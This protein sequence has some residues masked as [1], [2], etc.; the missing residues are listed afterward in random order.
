[1]TSLAVFFASLFG[2]PAVGSWFLPSPEGRAIKEL[3][4]TCIAAA[5]GLTTGL[6]I[7]LLAVPVSWKAATAVWMVYLTGTSILLG[8]IAQIWQVPAPGRSA[9]PGRRGSAWI[10]ALSFFISA[11]IATFAQIAVAAVLAGL[12]AGLG[13]PIKDPQDFFKS[14]FINYA[15]LC[16]LV[17]L[18][19]F[20]SLRWKRLNTPRD[21]FTALFSWVW[22]TSLGIFLVQGV[23]GSF[24]RNIFG[25]ELTTHFSGSRMTLMT[26]VFMFAGLPLV[27]Y[28]AWGRGS[29]GRRFAVTT[30]TMC[31]AFLSLFLALGMVPWA[32]CA[33]GRH[34]EKEGRPQA[35]LAWYGRS[36]ERRSTPLVVSY[37]EH[38][39]GL[40]NYKLGHKK[41]AI[42]AFKL[43]QTTNNANP[44]LARSAELYLDRLLSGAGGKR[45]VL[46]G[47]ETATDYRA[48][49]CAPNTLSVVLNYLHKDVSAS[50]VGEAISMVYQGTSITDI[51]LYC[52]R[53]GLDHILIPFATP[54]DCRFVIDHGYPFI[55][56]LPG[57]V[58]AVFGYD[59]RLRTLIAYDT[60]TWDIWVDHP[61]SSFLV[62]WSQENYLGAVILPRRRSKDIDRIRERYLNAGSRAA[63][64]MA[65][66]EN[67][68]WILDERRHLLGALAA[69]PTCLPAALNLFEHFPGFADAIPS[70]SYDG[71]M[72]RAVELLRRPS[73]EHWDLLSRYARFLLKTRQYNR[74]V[75][76]YNYLD[77]IGRG[78]KFR[79]Y[80][81]EAWF[82]LHNPSK[83]VPLLSGSAGEDAMGTLLLARSNEALGMRDEARD[84]FVHALQLVASNDKAKDRAWIARRAY[85][86]LEALHGEQ[87]GPMQAAPLREYL[88]FWPADAPRQLDYAR[89][90][91]N[92]VEQ[93][94]KHRHDN[95]LR[96][97]RAATLA[98]LLSSDEA[99]KARAQKILADIEVLLKH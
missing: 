45:V 25:I 31:C 10:P 33:W 36:L 19:L 69:D 40:L 88:R 6:F 59:T 98:M 78:A 30:V 39:I 77:A 63:W 72:K 64:L 18:F 80:A 60:A 12:P 26:V 52:D 28:T 16:I 22:V 1:M 61:Q 23:M 71:L 62:Q 38:R 8:I 29:L 42:N 34:L 9:R 91:V 94:G 7:L 49:Y 82:H 5:S 44:F 84:G 93:N 55:V 24:M 87:P 65:L 57:H 97:R 37:L 95:L 90:L 56:Y 11:F 53:L 85:T 2:T 75:L 4:F 76:L 20:L 92:G 13:A 35:A 83:A 27:L 68:R 89:C 47:V 43:L 79:L 14:I 86:R 70:S 54:E 99:L 96:A 50:Q 66:S 73:F 81:G 15:V 46:P 48:A 58:L 41:A 74:M 21:F 3:R 51:S 17:A 32:E 67:D